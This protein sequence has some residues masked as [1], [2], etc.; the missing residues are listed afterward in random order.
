MPYKG[1][2]KDQKE[3]SKRFRTL[4]KEMLKQQEKTT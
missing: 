1:I 2:K 3:L 4:F